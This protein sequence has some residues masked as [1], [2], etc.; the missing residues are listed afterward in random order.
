MTRKFFIVAAGFIISSHVNAQI[1]PAFP[2]DTSSS[3]Q[4][5]EVVITANKFQQKQSTTGKVVTVIDQ[6]TLQRLSGK[7]IS[8]IINYQAGV[9]IAGANN[10]LGTNQ[11]IYFRGAGTGNVLILIDG[12][13][14]GDPSQINNSFDINN[15][16]TGQVERIEILKGAQST[17]WGSD[18]TAGVINIITKKSGKK[19]ITPIAEIAYGSYSTV[20]GLAGING[21]LDRFTYNATYHFT[22]S[23]GFSAAKDST[24]TAGFDQDKYDQNSL[25]VNLAYQLTSNWSVKGF[26]NY[27][28]YNAAIDDGAFSDD[29]NFTSKSSNDIKNISLN[30]KAGNTSI[31][32]SNSYTKTTRNLLDDSLNESGFSKAFS[33][34][35][36]S[37]KSFVS[38][39]Y[40]N[41]RLFKSLSLVSGIQYLNQRS[42]QNG[43]YINSFGNFSSKLS[44]DSAKAENMSVYSSLLLSNVNG[45]NAEAGLRFN[46]HSVYGNNT[47]FTFNPSFSID[48]N[49]RVFLNISSGYRIPSLYQ[50][51]SEYGNKNLNPEQSGNYELGIQVS[52]HQKRSTFRLVVFK[53]D[54]HNLIVFY[55]NPTTFESAYINRDKQ[56]DFGFELE[57]SIGIGKMSRWVTNVTY[58]D[59]EGTEDKVKIKN[60]FRRPKFSLNSMLTAAPLKGLTV[61]PSLHV[62]GSRLKGI[63]DPGPNKMPG[64]YTLDLYAGYQFKKYLTFFTDFRNITNQ[65]YADIPG[66]NSREFNLMAGI[67]FSL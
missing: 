56:N 43:E 41:L 52:S 20:R 57:S 10:N 66:F 34:S 5:D 53:R 39:L 59:G 8:E 11:D 26:Y 38:D 48:K 15:I 36:Y 21:K 1:V 28:K 27:S 14:T 19:T 31:V 67:R 61:M 46:H 18:A 2:E 49:T 50:L 13:P 33:Q 6:A 7:T 12:I 51:Y 40:G 64:Y 63:Y 37:G 22:N 35:G 60:L 54:I 9:F 4:L 65:Q 47:T 62:I 30:Y 44:G 17:L 45:F 32:F 55:T 16:T 24:E 42:D 29:K 3:K 58:V 23:K 25:Q